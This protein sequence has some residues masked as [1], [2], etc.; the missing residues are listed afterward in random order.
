MPKSKVFGFRVLPGNAL[1]NRSMN[2][3]MQADHRYKIAG[4][5]DQPNPPR[6]RTLLHT[7]TCNGTCILMRKA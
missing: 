7:A 6:C 2:A 3:C 5:E 1:R 4:M